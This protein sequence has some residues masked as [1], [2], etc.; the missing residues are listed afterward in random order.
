MSS[1]GSFFFFLGG[2]SKPFV[3]EGIGGAESVACSSSWYSVLFWLGDSGVVAVVS[4]RC[5]GFGFEKSRSCMDDIL[6][7]GVGHSAWILLGERCGVAAS[8]SWRNTLSVSRRLPALS[9]PGAHMESLGSFGRFVIG[10][11]FAL[12]LDWPMTPPVLWTSLVD[13][14]V[15]SLPGRSGWHGFADCLDNSVAPL[16]QAAGQFS[17]QWSSS[18]TPYQP[19][20]FTVPCWFLQLDRSQGCRCS[21]LCLG[22]WPNRDFAPIRRRSVSLRDP[23]LLDLSR[24]G[25]RWKASLERVHVFSEGRFGPWGWEGIMAEEH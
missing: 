18:S 7:R 8:S 9:I 25:T 24:V 16:R 14:F 22:A 12:V 3:E 4:S 13:V 15:P 20:G 21:S 1:V 19:C 6:A 23:W 17:T 2:G 11:R 5:G 10:S